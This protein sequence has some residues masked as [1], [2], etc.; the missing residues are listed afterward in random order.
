MNEISSAASELKYNL[1]KTIKET[2]RVKSDRKS[3][4]HEI[5]NIS[6]QFTKIKVPDIFEELGI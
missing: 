2:K 4:I 5:V 3:L 1:E 6:K